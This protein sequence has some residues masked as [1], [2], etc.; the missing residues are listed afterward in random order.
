MPEP[1]QRYYNNDGTVA[2]GCY[3]YTYAAGTTTPKATY[4]DSAG[5]TANAN[6]VVLD[7]KGEAIIYWDGSY[8]VDLKTAAGVQI[9]GYPV[10]N[11]VSMT[12]SVDG[13][14]FTNYVATITT[15]K[16]TTTDLFNG[17]VT[18]VLGYYAAGDGGGG[19][20]KWNS[21]ST[22][23][24]DGGM[25]IQVTGVATGRWERISFG[26]YYARW[27]GVRGDGSTDDTTKMQV[28]F[29]ASAANPLIITAGTYMC[30]S[31]TV[32]SGAKITFMPGA[33][34]KAISSLAY[35]ATLIKNA[36]QG[37][38][39]DSDIE[40][41][42]LCVDGNGVG[43]GGTQTRFTELVSF[44]RVTNLRLI[45]PSI[46][47]VEYMGLAIGGCVRVLISDP[48]VTTCGYNGTTTNGGAA[49]WCAPSG[50]DQCKYVEV[51]GG[52]IHDNRWHGMTF[53]V[54][55]GIVS[56]VSFKSNQEAHIFISRSVALNLLSNDIVISGNTFDTVT[57][58]DISGSAIETGGYGMVITNNT[59]RTCAQNGIALTD[60]QGAVVSGNYIENFNLDTSVNCA[61]ISILTTEASP[62]QPTHNTIMGN[63]IRDTQTVKT[64]YAGIAIDRAG[65]AVN[66]VIIK[67]NNLKGWTPTGGVMINIAAGKWG[68]DCIRSG[69]IGGGD[70]SPVHG[71]FTPS[72]GT[73]SKSVTGIGFKPRRLEFLAV[74]TSTSVLQ[75]SNSVVDSAGACL[76]HSL[77]ASTADADGRSSGNVAW[78]VKDAA[79]TAL[80][81]ATFTSYDDD[82]FT[83]NI[84]TASTDLVVRYVAYP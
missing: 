67:D 22:T 31:L 25:T 8:K 78:A 6:P 15:L 77:S 55:E 68:A 48:D 62:D 18:Q 11:Y 36:T 50:T 32:P 72:A 27:F 1:R 60:V 3:L 45:R 24:D 64:G 75:H 21:S 53:S 35:N 49:I 40:I 9:T 42:G 52:H 37:S 38:Y 16:A 34:I 39:T 59:I 73:G 76:C 56:G 10:D 7:S 70:E 30:G 83:Y 14:G 47:N 33:K 71:S 69:N 63:V 17:K 29:S 65:S 80:A 44:G 4:S 12:T 23:A 19:T 81:G 2:A 43:S 51:R 79:G 57:K 61:G 46:S 20:F 66:N 54:Q 26:Q 84:T 74:C 5:T 58:R 82:G 41:I 28:A 13:Q